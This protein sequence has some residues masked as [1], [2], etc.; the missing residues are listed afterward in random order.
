MSKG[1]LSERLARVEATAGPTLAD[2]TE[3]EIDRRILRAGD[4]LAA[5]DDPLDD[6]NGGK[7]R[8]LM[9]QDGIVGAPDLGL[10][11]RALWASARPAYVSAPGP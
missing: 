9:A 2:L 3:E 8:Q 4:A 10:G 6:E 5:I 1:S 11:F 7:I